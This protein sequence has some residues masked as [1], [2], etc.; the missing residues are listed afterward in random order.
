[1]VGREGVS[2]AILAA[3]ANAHAFE[4]LIKVRILD[5]CDGDRKQVARE[6]AEK[7]GSALVQVL[8]RT[9]LLYTPDPEDPQIKLPSQ[10][11]S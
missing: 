11:S 7:S 5:T 8:G 10:S 9:L 2:E 1:M 3:V 4:E 6:L